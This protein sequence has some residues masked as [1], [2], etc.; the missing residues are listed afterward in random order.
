M[1]NSLQSLLGKSIKS[2]E[3]LSFMKEFKLPNNPKRNLDTAND[4]YDTVSKNKEN[5]IHM[6]FDGY[7]RYKQEYGEPE[8][9]NTENKDDLFLDE[10]TIDPNYEKTKK[11]AITPLPFEL[12]LGDSKETVLKKTGKKPY[13]KGNASYGYYYWTQFD[14]FRILTAFNS[15]FQLIWI[16]I[17]KLT[18]D[19]KAKIELKKFLSQQ[20]KNIKPDNHK[21][22]IEYTNKVPTIEWKKRKEKGDTVFTENNIIAIENLLKDYLD[23]LVTLTINKKA[24]NIYNSTKKLVQTINKINNQNNSFIETME[25]EELCEFINNVIRTTGFDFDHTIDLTEEWR[26][27]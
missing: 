14:D 19:E 24:T 17:I 4:A 5:G 2:E 1:A 18:L 26:E 23:T 9:M 10:I 8:T 27:W 22:I 20:N 16:R 7:N 12:L 6:N 25:R 11:N 21:F 15:D 3:L 13:D